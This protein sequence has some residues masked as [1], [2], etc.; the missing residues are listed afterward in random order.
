MKNSIFGSE[1]V[2][3]ENIN[4][5]DFRTYFVDFELQD[6]GSY[7]YRWKALIN[8]LQNALVEFAYGLHEGDKTVNSE[9]I[10]KLV[11]SAKS[12]YKIKEYKEVQKLFDKGENIN[13]LDST[14]K[15]LKRGEFG[16]LILHLLLR[17]FHKT[18]PLLSKIY[19]KDSYGYT[20]HGFDGVHIQPD[21]K[22]LWLGESKLY[23]NGKAGIK[24]L[25]NDL[26][27]HFKRDYLQDE[28]NIISKK[29]KPYD[30]VPEKDY[31]LNLMD[32]KIKLQD[33]LTSVTIPLL[34]TYS[35]NNFNSYSIRLEDNI[36][37]EIEIMKKYFDK[38]NNHPLKTQLNIILLLFPVK[39]KNELVKKMHQKLFQ[40]Q[41]LKK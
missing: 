17:D 28:F 26:K 1:K 40:L 3:N 12:I 19:F 25:I 18:I 39:C 13:D 37:K 38:H 10:D 7:Q 14:K 27:E 15:Y 32:Q 22:T 33:I 29:I 2:I 9:I 41:S 20:V 21:N 6:D 23:V 34:C 36:K 16:E 5:S 11:D 31:W 30:D 8:L 35:S 24:E 4:G